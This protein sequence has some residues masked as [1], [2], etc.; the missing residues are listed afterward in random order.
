MFRAAIEP[1]LD[2]IVRNMKTPQQRRSDAVCIAAIL[3]TIAALLGCV[4]LVTEAGR[5]RITG[6][7][8]AYKSGIASIFCARASK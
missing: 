6:E 3:L 5:G 1:A 4:F 8:P 7:Y 2:A